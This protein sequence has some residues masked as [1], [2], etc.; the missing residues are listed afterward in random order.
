MAHD[1][2]RKATQNDLETEFPNRGRESL[3]RKKLNVFKCC[4]LKVNR[5]QVSNQLS[6]SAAVFR[7]TLVESWARVALHCIEIALS[8]RCERSDIL[9]YRAKAKAPVGPTVALQ[10]WVSKAF[11]G[12]GTGKPRH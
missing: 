3:G 9:R 2:S 1:G 7:L 4:M 12:C 11:S 10:S 5:H 8:A 6:E